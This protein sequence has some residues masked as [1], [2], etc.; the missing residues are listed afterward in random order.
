[1]KQIGVSQG[2]SVTSVLWHP[3]IN[4]IVVGTSN[5][6]VHI[7]YDPTLSTNGALLS[8]VKKPREKDP[9]DYEPPR[10]I[11]TP[12]ALPLFYE[13]PNSKRKAAKLRMDPRK[14]AKI[15]G[16][17]VGPAPPKRSG[18][19]VTQYLMQNYITKDVTRDEDPREALLK[20]ADAD[21]DP[22]FFAAYK[23]TQPKKIFNL[24][25]EP[26]DSRVQPENK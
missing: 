21:K 1:V 15:E 12:H 17:I 3:K 26:Q 19:S 7:F 22:F 2:G 24:S 25:Q 14:S 6:N 8:L 9:N 10:P 11:L 18:S 4:Q 16:N 23:E 13:T 5:S 20:F